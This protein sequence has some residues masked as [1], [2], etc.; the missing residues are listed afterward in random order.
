[1]ERKVYGGT[2]RRVKLAVFRY[3]AM[4]KIEQRPESLSLPAGEI[5]QRAWCQTN[6]DPYVFKNCYNKWVIV[7]SILNE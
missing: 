2:G 5:C 6:S 7:L 4:K 3:D 1:M